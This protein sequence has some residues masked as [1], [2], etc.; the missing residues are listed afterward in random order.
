LRLVPARN[1]QQEG[2]RLAEQYAITRWA[3]SL[4][5]LAH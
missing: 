2:V 5:R 3:Q 4:V 1:N